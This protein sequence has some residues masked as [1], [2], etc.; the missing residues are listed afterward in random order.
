MRSFEA[1]ARR[2][3]FSAA[4]EELFLTQSA[5]SRQIKALEEEVGAPLLTRGTRSVALTGAGSSLLQALV[6]ALE[7]IDGAVRQLREARSRTVVNVSTYASFA[8]MWLLPRLEAF[9]QSHPDCDIRVS[10]GDRLID[11]DDPEHDVILRHGAVGIAPPGA[12]RLFGEVLTPVMSPWLLERMRRGEA[13]ALQSVADLAAYTLI[14]QGDQH[15]N[16]HQRLSWR[17]WLVA[18]GSADLQ[19]RRWVELNYSYQQTQAALAGQGVALARLPL[20]ADMLARGE[21]VEPFGPSGR[22]DAGTA[23]WVA[24]TAV[25][26]ERA[27][28]QTFVAWV[29]AQ[30]ALTRAAIGDVLDA[31]VD[32]GPGEGD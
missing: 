28:V 27:D 26:R 9:E 19:P 15:V 11:A 1:V 16:A 5:V 31:D 7:R 21:L 3:S 12:T 13:P 8:S 29:R 30:A 24:A 10:S 23:Y 2:L 25:G 6:P 17:T 14:E 22:Q 32:A 4:A 20:V 18:H